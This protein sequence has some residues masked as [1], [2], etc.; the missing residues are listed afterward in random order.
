MP[1]PDKPLDYQTPKPPSVNRPRNVMLR[2]LAGTAAGSGSAAMGVWL[3]NLTQSVIVGFLPVAIVF[4]VAL[5]VSIRFKRRGYA[6][7]IVLA[8]FIVGGV[9]MLLLLMICGVVIV[10]SA[11]HR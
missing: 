9:L 4:C 5:Y 3:Y 8:P 10:G 2:I 7:G 1:D 6:A 11:L